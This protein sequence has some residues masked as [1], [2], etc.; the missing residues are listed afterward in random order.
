MIVLPTDAAECSCGQNFDHANAGTQPSSEQIR[1]KAEELYENYLIARVAQATENVKITQAEFARDA[2]NPDKSKRVT[3]AIRALQAAESALSAQS[4]HVAE[5]KQ[6]LLPPP[7]ARTA[8]AHRMKKRPTA[9]ALHKTTAVVTHINVAAS[10]HVK[11]QATTVSATEE[12]TRAFAPRK[13]VNV[14]AAPVAKTAP[15]INSPT[16][17]VHQSA[18]VTASASPAVRA[19]HPLKIV[20]TAPKIT[21]APTAAS[22]PAPRRTDDVSPTQTVTPAPAFRQA[23]SAKAEKILHAKHTEPTRI[24]TDTG[25]QMTHATPIVELQQQSSAPA[26]AM[27][28][29]RPLV[30]RNENECPN[31][32]AVVASKATRCRC[33][34][35]FA[36]HEQLMPALAMSEEDRA[37]FARLLGAP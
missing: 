12:V 3:A 13:M 31:C 37:A 35:E 18:A 25:G 22:T 4:D 8:A 21:P 20:P 36:S 14:P 7:P 16:P 27:A 15:S 1:L 23:Q 5:M 6:A 33:G 2:S 30:L 34:Y 19:K 17:V 29:P 9:A 24:V 32:T 11:R 10:A 28:A 26:A